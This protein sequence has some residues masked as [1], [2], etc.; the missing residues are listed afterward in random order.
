MAMAAAQLKEHGA[1]CDELRHK[2]AEEEDAATVAATEQ[3]LARATE[4]SEA[5]DTDARRLIQGA[6]TLSCNS[7]EPSMP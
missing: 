7:T 5:T 4:F 1:L 6:A 2:F 3:L